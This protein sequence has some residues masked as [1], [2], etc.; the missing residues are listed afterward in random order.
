MDILNYIFIGLFVILFGL[1]IQGRRREK[2]R[3]YRDFLRRLITD[4]LVLGMTEYCKLQISDFAACL[5]DRKPM[6]VVK[7]IF[8]GM[9]KD[10]NSLSQIRKR[11]AD[12][13]WGKV[14]FYA[15][16]MDNFK[17]LS[18]QDWK[19]VFIKTQANFDLVDGPLR[20]LYLVV[21]SLSLYSEK[22]TRELALKKLD[23]F[24]KKVREEALAVINHTEFKK[25]IKIEE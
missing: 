19:K 15:V 9:T 4:S 3:V 11:F 18:K 16:L 6:Q 10:E 17:Q 12:P 14:H 25:I 2:K 13:D 22:E 8:G 23:S 1:V 21:A 7:D 24:P 5:S 20:K